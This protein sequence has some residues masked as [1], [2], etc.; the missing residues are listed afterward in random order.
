MRLRECLSKT[1]SA[2]LVK[3]KRALYLPVLLEACG[4]EQ[5]S[6]EYRHGTI[7][8]GAFTY[9]MVKN[10]RH[11]PAITFQALVARTGETL[12]A[13]R[14]DQTPHIVG[15]TKVVRSRVPGA[16]PTKSKR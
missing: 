10:L 13:L 14:Y 2:R 16:G 7:S 3:Q 12:R 8:Y 4:E 15:P 6:Y 11:H 1:E 5:F 9:S